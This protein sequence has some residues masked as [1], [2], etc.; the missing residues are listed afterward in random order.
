MR[1][2]PGQSYEKPTFTSNFCEK[3]KGV[4]KMGKQLVDKILPVLD[5]IIW[6]QSEAM[7]QFGLQTYEM[8]MDWVDQYEEDVRV[9]QT[10]IN[11]LSLIHI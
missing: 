3:D 1:Y 6:P 9:I 2:Q 7:T 4:I 5:K 10:A 8:G 11:T